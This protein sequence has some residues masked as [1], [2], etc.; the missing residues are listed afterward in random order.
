MRKKMFEKAAFELASQVR[1]VEDRI[2]AAL[3][4]IAELQAQM[5]RARTITRAGIISSHP[6]FEQLA[7]VTSALVNARGGI[8]NCHV[9][10]AEAQKTIPG[11][12]TVAIGD[13]GNCPPAAGA[14]PLRIVA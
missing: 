7:V 9:A 5:V 12:R 14:K 11:L 3:I 13:D 8:A 2:E 10:L 6:A 4:D 1:A